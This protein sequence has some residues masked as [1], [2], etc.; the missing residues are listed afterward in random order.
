MDKESAKLEVEKIVK[1]FLSIPKSERDS[2]P[3]EKINPYY[4]LGLLNSKNRDTIFKKGLTTYS[5]KPLL[6]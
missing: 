4:L 2:M 3:E 6:L 5:D 1:K